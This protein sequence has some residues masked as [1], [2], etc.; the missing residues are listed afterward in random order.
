[1]EDERSAHAEDAAEKA[2]FE[3]DIVSR[4]R[5]ARPRLRRSRCAARRPVVLGKN[6]RREID[7]TGKLEKAFQRR[8]PGIEGRHPGHDVHD[9]AEAASQC[10]EQLFL[11][12]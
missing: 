1:M 9:I 3:H 2:G 11:F 8:G 12:S 5:L 10:L 4:R 7:F 6:K